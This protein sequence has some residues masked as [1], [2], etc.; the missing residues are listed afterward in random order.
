M[1]KQL[2]FYLSIVFVIISCSKV[3]NSKHNNSTDVILNQEKENKPRWAESTCSVFDASGN[4]VCIGT[5]CSS[6]MGHCGARKETKCKC[7]SKSNGTFTLPIGMS[8]ED[9]KNTWNDSIGYEYL[10]GLGFYEK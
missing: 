7:V 10:T 4:E 1:K 5:R 8:F 2:F 9:F 3:E 6:P